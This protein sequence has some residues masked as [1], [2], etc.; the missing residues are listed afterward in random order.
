[1]HLVPAGMWR[2][3]AA[4]W[5][6]RLIGLAAWALATMWLLLGFWAARGWPRDLPGAVVLIAA[7]LLLGA[8]L[9][10]TCQIAFLAGGGQTLGHMALGVAVVRNDG[11]RVGFGRAALR[12]L[13]GGL[14]TGLT[15]GLGALVALFNRERRG[16]ADL[17]A[18][19]RLVRVN[20]A[21]AAPSE[22]WRRERPPGAEEGPLERSSMPPMPVTFSEALAVSTLEPSGNTTLG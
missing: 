9:H 7:I 10:V 11:A 21:D 20:A 2:R 18:G 5:V 8:A 13:G 4:W 22:G 6:D 15:L 12:C 3:F 16:I 17:V 19:T 14:L 1:M